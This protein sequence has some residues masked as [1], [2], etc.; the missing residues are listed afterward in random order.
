MRHYHNGENVID[1]IHDAIYEN[2]NYGSALFGENIYL[3][4]YDFIVKGFFKRI[5]AVH[6]AFDL[7]SGFLDT[8]SFVYSKNSLESFVNSIKV[9]SKISFTRLEAFMNLFNHPSFYHIIGDGLGHSES[10][11]ISYMAMCC[12]GIRYV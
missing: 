4:M 12:L 5:D 8:P 11:A 3:N 1:F 7:G 10:S 9:D 2:K 6:A